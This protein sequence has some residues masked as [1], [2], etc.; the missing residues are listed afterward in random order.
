MALRYLC[1]PS[2]SPKSQLW[3]L[4]QSLTSDFRLFTNDRWLWIMTC[5]SFKASAVSESSSVRPGEQII[6]QVGPLHFIEW[7]PLQLKILNLPCIISTES[8]SWRLGSDSPEGG[9]SVFTAR[10][11]LPGWFILVLFVTACDKMSWESVSLVLQILRWVR[12]FAGWMQGVPQH[13]NV[14]SWQTYRELVKST[15]LE[16]PA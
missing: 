1:G 2:A 15:S 11:G 6:L 13:R 8:C 5:G 7:K 9:C 14:G 4:I 12:Q 10:L 16:W 3:G